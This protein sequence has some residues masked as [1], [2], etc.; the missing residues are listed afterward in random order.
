MNNTAKMETL[1]TQYTMIEGH[2]IAYKEMG[3]GQPLLLLHGIP[4]NK[5]LWTHVM[6][7]LAKQ[8]RVIAPDMLNYG[9]SD[10]PEN[11]DV[12][13]NAQTRIM[14]KLM[15]ALGIDSADVVSHDI[16]GGI[17]QLLAVNHGQRVRR[18][19]LIDSVCFDSWPIPE[20]EEMLEPGVEEST[21]V[22]E[23]ISTM[24]G[25]MPN[26]VYD[27][28]VVTE[29]MADRYL[30]QWNSEKGKAAFFRNMRRLNKE[31][32]QAIADELKNIE[33]K[34][35]VLWADKDNF[36]KPKYAPMLADAIPGAKLV[37]I[38]N[39]GHWVTDE[40]PEAVTKHILEFLKR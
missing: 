8:Y 1:D 38:E 23:F 3:E 25:F 4:T 5:M 30:N 20:F 22:E 13:I 19:V 7:E 36:Q 16:G 40:K 9:E 15:D 26:G 24:R 39:A 21:S 18:Q 37:W 11:A 34:T 2:R 35:L 12:S 27:D 14:V 17:G 6:P 33:N 28:D 31:Y 29:E 10:M 32:T